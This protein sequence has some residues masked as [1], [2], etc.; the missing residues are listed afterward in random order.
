[1]RTTKIFVALALLAVSLASV[2][3]GSAVQGRQPIT[4]SVKI[5]GEAVA[6]GLISFAPQAGQAGGMT[7]GGTIKDGKYEIE[8]L[9][10]LV[11]GTYVVSFDV[12]KSTGNTISM[13][14]ASGGTM[15][16]EEKVSVVPDDYSL[17]P[18]HTVEIKK[19]KNTLDFDIPARE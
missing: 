1:V 3:C 8:A 2:G 12:Q 18:T 5:G 7:A 4:G 6:E 16:V 11:P 19:G 17:A 9:H 14:D 15:E 13:P 10:G